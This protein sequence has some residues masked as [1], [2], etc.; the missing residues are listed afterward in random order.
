LINGS[1]KL[2]IEIMEK[3]TNRMHEIQHKTKMLGIKTIT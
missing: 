1:L 2:N 3:K